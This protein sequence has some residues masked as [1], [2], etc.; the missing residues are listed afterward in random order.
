M[1]FNA[2][3][4][5]GVLPVQG[6]VDITSTPNCILTFG[7]VVL[8]ACGLPFSVE[9]KVFGTGMRVCLVS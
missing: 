2:S 9:S 7:V 6:C 1:V 5:V 8:D 4:I 3:R